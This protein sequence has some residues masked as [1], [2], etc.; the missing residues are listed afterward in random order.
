MKLSYG[1]FVAE[2]MSATDRVLYFT[3]G[4][5]RLTAMRWTL[6]A[7]SVVAVLAVAATPSHQATS[8]GPLAVDGDD[9]LDD[10]GRLMPAEMLMSAS[11]A[12]D[13]SRQALMRALPSKAPL[14][15][16]WSDLSTSLQRCEAAR[17]TESA[18]MRLM[19]SVL[20]QTDHLQDP[21]R[22]H[23]TRQPPRQVSYRLRLS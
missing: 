17:G 9:D 20:S 1:Y 11:T 3:G 16:S 14:G 7:A 4:S 22:A 5:L 12:S 18:F 6:L 23:A 13:G 15:W 2:K 8:W 21:L 10:L 19:E